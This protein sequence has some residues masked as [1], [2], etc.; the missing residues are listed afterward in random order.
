M[1][2]ALMRACVHTGCSAN[3]CGGCATA[4]KCAGAYEKCIWNRSAKK[5][6]A[7]PAIAVR[8]KKNLVAYWDFEDGPANN[9]HKVTDV[10]GHGHDGRSSNGGRAKWSSSSLG[11]GSWA[12]NFRRTSG[13]T[14]EISNPHGFPSGSAARTIVTWF[15]NIGSDGDLQLFFQGRWTHA[16]GWRMGMHSSGTRPYLDVR[17]YTYSD[18][19]CAQQQSRLT[20]HHALMRILGIK[21]CCGL[22]VHACK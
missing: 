4:N 2:H 22:R 12:G 21:A 18:Y 15:R 13:D 20:Y 8:L 14:V 16:Q 5:C 6:L 9:Q 7:A 10:T 3:H 11:G 19:T 1:C 17:G